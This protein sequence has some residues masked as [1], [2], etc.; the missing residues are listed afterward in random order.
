MFAYFQKE[1]EITEK[2]YTDRI[3]NYEIAL[4]ADIEWIKIQQ[5][6]G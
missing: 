3:Q 4:T 1:D 2:D 6:E 5:E